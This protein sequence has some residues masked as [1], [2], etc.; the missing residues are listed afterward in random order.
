MADLR[1]NELPITPEPVRFRA[2]FGQRFLVT[3][4]AEEEFDWREPLDRHQH[5]VDS[6]PALRK[7]QQFC[8]GFGVAPVYLVD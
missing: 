1:I 6:V 2:G 4:D 8:E 7:F 3:V 5:R